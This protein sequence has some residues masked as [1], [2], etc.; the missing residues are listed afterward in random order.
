LTSRGAVVSI[1]GEIF[2]TRLFRLTS[3]PLGGLLAAFLSTGC[4][5]LGPTSPGE[6]LPNASLSVETFNSTLTLQGEAFYSFTVV[7]GG[8]TYLTL[9]TL[10]EGGVDSQAQVSIGL[11]VPRGTSCV[12]D[13]VRG[14]LAGGGVQ[15]TGT[16]NRGVHC[17]L[18]F[19]S[20]N[21]TQS[22][23]FSLNIAR[24]Q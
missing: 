17:A 4:S 19:D 15:L 5:P 2:V 20:G 1:Q 9:L 24:P 16:T 6:I 10:K 18:V 11:G 3:L 13:N 7:D 21:L 8:I 23:T 14:V 12:A 22:A